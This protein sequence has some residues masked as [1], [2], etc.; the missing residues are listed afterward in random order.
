MSAQS[1]DMRKNKK[2]KKSFIATFQNLFKSSSKRQ[3]GPDLPNNK[4]ELLTYQKN[5]EVDT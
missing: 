2:A 4:V 3:Q 1:E 5:T